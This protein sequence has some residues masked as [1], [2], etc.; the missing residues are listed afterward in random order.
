VRSEVLRLATWRA[1]RSG[2]DDGLVDVGTGRPAPASDVVGRLVDHV[3]DSLEEAGRLDVVRGLVEQVFGRGGG[4]SAQR[5]L[6][7]GGAGAPRLVRT[8]AARTAGLDDVG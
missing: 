5:A 2:L 3:R 1:S 4:A 6:R 7:R 8:L